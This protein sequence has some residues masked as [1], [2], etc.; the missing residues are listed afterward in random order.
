MVLM[1]ELSPQISRGILVMDSVGNALREWWVK[2]G[3]PPGLLIRTAKMDGSV[4]SMNGIPL[5]ELTDN[6]GRGD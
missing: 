6:G 1:H 2:R 4:I 3:I 5:L